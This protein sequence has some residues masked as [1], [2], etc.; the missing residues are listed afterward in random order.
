MSF[1][2]QPVPSTTYR[3][4]RAKVSDGK[5][6]RVSVPA[7]SGAVTAGTL[8]YFGGFV[9]FA[10]QSLVNDAANAQD[11]VLQIEIAEYETDQVKTTDTLAAGTKVFWDAENK[12]LTETPTSIFAGVIT[13]AKDTNNVIWFLLVPGVLGDEAMTA[14]GDM[15]ELTTTEKDEIVAAI[16]EVNN[17]TGA[18]QEDATT[19]LG[20]VAANVVCAADA[21]AED[22]RTA[23]RALLTALEAA[24]LMAGA[25]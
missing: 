12:R 16:N 5:S 18:A 24:G 20:R 19:A 8:V 6:V 13:V 15:A 1:T 14:I 23:V 7:G 22:V 2:G 3:S 25:A 17:A 4:A 9:G 21:S 11:L 10:M